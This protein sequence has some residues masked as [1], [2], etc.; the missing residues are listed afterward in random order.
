[1]P[2]RADL[3]AEIHRLQEQLAAAESREGPNVNDM[4]VAGRVAI[5][6]LRDTDFPELVKAV[7]DIPAIYEEKGYL[8]ALAYCRGHVRSL[9]DAIILAVPRTADLVRSQHRLHM[10][11]NEGEA[12]LMMRRDQ[13]GLRA[14]MEFLECV[15]RYAY[16]ASVQAAFKHG[17]ETPAGLVPATFRQE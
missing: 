12:D 7:D 15:E 14:R 1:M 4:G 13:A 16:A 17:A 3:E 2:R 11:L 8:P 6:R 5:T 9:V 10:L